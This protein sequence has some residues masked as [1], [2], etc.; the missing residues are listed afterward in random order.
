M[1]GD[2]DSHG[3]TLSQRPRVGGK[4]IL[5]MCAIGRSPRLVLA[6][7][8]RPRIEAIRVVDMSASNSWAEFAAL[9]RNTRSAFL[10]NERGQKRAHG[11]NA[12]G[13]QGGHWA[14]CEGEALEIGGGKL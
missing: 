5:A 7:P 10:D 12:G 3:P 4:E 2:R 6:E 8:P 11:P 14:W 1:G 9:F 13:C